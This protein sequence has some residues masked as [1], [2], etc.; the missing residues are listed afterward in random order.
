MEVRVTVGPT[1][2]T[3]D[4]DANGDDSAKMNGSDPPAPRQCKIDNFQLVKLAAALAVGLTGAG[5]YSV[6]TVATV[7]VS[8]MARA[9]PALGLARAY[10]DGFDVLFSISGVTESVQEATLQVPSHSSS[11]LTRKKTCETW[12]APPRAHRRARGPPR[13]CSRC[14]TRGRRRT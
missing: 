6:V 12:Q 11:S 10:R 5:G 4:S 7:L 3:R 13:R 14:S 1:D 2:L 8:D 9:A